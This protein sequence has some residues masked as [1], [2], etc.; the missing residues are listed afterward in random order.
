MAEQAARVR[1]ERPEDDEVLVDQKKGKRG[2]PEKVLV[3]D[4]R[5]K[6]R[7]KKAKKPPSTLKSLLVAL[8]AV[9]LLFGAAGA[10]VF[11][12]IFGAKRIL[13]DTLDLPQAAADVREERLRAW[14]TELQNDAMTLK[15]ERDALDM[16]EKEVSGRESEAEAKTSELD[17]KIAEYE[18][19]RAQLSEENTDIN[20]VIKVLESMSAE[21]AAPALLAMTDRPSMLR[22]FTGLKTATQSALLETMTAEEAAYILEHL[23]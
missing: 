9:I 6:K 21:T 20:D 8:T 7:E 3:R 1:N 2:R 15:N 14:E 16:K 12:D 23:H 17:G 22:V 13:A 10:L 11:F 5:K 19:M 18:E 4:K